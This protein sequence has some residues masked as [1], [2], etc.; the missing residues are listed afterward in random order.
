VNEIRSIGL[1][2]KGDNEFAEVVIWKSRNTGTV[3]EWSARTNRRLA[4]VKKT[5]EDLNKRIENQ[6]SSRLANIPERNPMT[7][8]ETPQVLNELVIAKLDAYARRVQFE[9]EMSGKYGFNSTPR[10]VMVVKIKA[11]WWHTPDGLAV[12]DLLRD[13]G[14]EPVDLTKI[15][16]T[17]IEAYAA[18]GRLDA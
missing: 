5:L 18:I 2:G 12:K 9:G 13:R 3:A 1:V 10:E 7:E 15:A 4:D 16:K 17:H 11:K 14:F 8:K 6:R